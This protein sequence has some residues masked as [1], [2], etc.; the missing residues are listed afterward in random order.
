M[1]GPRAARSAG[2]QPRGEQS[3]EPLGNL[4]T[5]PRNRP[6][7]PLPPALPRMR[8]RWAATE[9]EGESPFPLHV[10]QAAAGGFL[11]GPGGALPAWTFV[12][13]LRLWASSHLLTRSAPPL[14]AHLSGCPAQ[15]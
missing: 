8:E 9:G 11:K 15:A 13:R 7:T 14:S 5:G 1:E 10:T 4:L 6:D 12:P 3:P 2:G